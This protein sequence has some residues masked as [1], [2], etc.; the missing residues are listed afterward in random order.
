M[1]VYEGGITYH[2]VVGRS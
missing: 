1:T 2:M